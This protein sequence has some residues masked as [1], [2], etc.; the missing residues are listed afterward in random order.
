MKGKKGLYAIV[1]APSREIA[2]Q[3]QAVFDEFGTPLGVRSVAVI[4]GIDIKND[5]KALDTNPQV[6]VATPGRLCDHLD[7]GNLWLDFI[8]AVVLDE[9]D[10]MLE[11]GFSEQ[12]NRILDDTPET[13]Q[14]LL[15]SATFPPPV[16]RLAQKI[17]YKPER[18]QIG[19]T[20]TP[21]QSVDQ[22]FV[23]VSEQSKVSELVRLLLR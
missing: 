2:L 8:E 4:G 22:Q 16:E 19:K 11:M 12:L 1:L 17:L 3:V 15:F 18:V 23:F 21:V 5:I 9:A 10:R 14:T 13:R 6:I 20:S 7:R